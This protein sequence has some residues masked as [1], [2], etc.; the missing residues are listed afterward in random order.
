MGLPVE[1]PQLYS[2]LAVTNIFLTRRASR[3]HPRQFNVP[4][5]E[6]LNI[7][8]IL[9]RDVVT[10]QITCLKIVFSANSE[11][12]KKKIILTDKPLKK[13]I[14]QQFREH[15]NYKRV[16]KFASVNVPL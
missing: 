2:L 11:K 16:V 9:P 8:L 1:G 10:A 14:T 15:E 13:V 6:I 7:V 4:K 5:C 12:N 3:P